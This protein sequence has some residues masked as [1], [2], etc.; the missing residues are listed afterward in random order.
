MEETEE[1]ATK[2]VGTSISLLFTYFWKNIQIKCKTY[3]IHKAILTETAKSNSKI[4]K[5]P[6]KTPIT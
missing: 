6:Q 4:H 1:T 2:P 5:E 3:Q